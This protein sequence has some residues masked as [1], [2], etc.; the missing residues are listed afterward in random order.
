MYPGGVCKGSS[1]HDMQP[2]TEHQIS[3][4]SLS[5][6][7]VEQHLGASPVKHSNS[8]NSL[9][10]LASHYPP[11]S[12][13][14]KITAMFAKPRALPT[15]FVVAV[16]SLLANPAA[17]DTSDPHINQELPWPPSTPEGPPTD[18]PACKAP[19]ED[20]PKD[21]ISAFKQH[22]IEGSTASCS[23]RGSGCHQIDSW[24]QAAMSTKLSLC[25]WD[26]QDY[27]YGQSVTCQSTNISA[28]LDALVASCSASQ[29]TITGGQ[30]A[31]PAGPRPPT[32][33][34][35]P[36]GEAGDWDFKNAM[37]ISVDRVPVN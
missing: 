11:K 2:R 32:D 16:F 7:A 15:A 17:C 9:L 30:A 26:D 8:Y 22:L 19:S 31:I 1:P 20:L 14:L 35:D 3:Q 18:A 10:P 6:L 4:A 5:T 13:R 27:S 23:Y 28:A 33:S 29:W 34:F 36:V 12:Q 21:A 24:T 25:G 37:F